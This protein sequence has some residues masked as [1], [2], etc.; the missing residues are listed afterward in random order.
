MPVYD[1]VERHHI[2]V[3]APAAVTLAVARDTN[4]FDVPVVRAVFKGRELI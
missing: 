1:V 4:L 3:A 2:H